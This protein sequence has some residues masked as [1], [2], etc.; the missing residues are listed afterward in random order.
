MVY[1]EA[2]TWILRKWQAVLSL[3]LVKKTLSLDLKAKIAFALYLV[4]LSIYTK[5]WKA[6]RQHKVSQITSRRPKEII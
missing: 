6:V 5:I 3:I 1:T 4:A 2:E